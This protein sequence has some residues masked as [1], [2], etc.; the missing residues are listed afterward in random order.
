[1]IFKTLKRNTFLK[2]IILLLLSVRLVHSQDMN[3][4]DLD[5][6]IFTE[7]ALVNSHDILVLYTKISL[8]LK[9]AR[10]NDY[11]YSFYF[12]DNYS[13]KLPQTE[14]QVEVDSSYIGGVGNTL[15]FKFV[16]EKSTP[17]AILLLEVKSKVSGK[18]FLFDVPVYGSLPFNIFN[19]KGEP[20]V[21][22]WAI[23]GAYKLLEPM[24]TTFYYSHDFPPALPPMVTHQELEDKKIVVDS[25]FMVRG[26]LVL[27]KRGLYLSQTDTTSTK[28]LSFRVEDK[29]FPKF[30]TMDQLVEPLIYITSKE[31]Q[32]KLSKIN[33]EKRLFDK[34][35]LDLTKSP[36]RAK[37]I[38]RT[39]Y[40]RIESANRLF[41]TFKEGWKTDMGMIYIVMGAPDEVER[42]IKEETWVYLGN[43]DLPKRKFT[44]I[45][46]NSIFSSA[47]YVLIR[48]KKHAEAWF[49]AIDL[50]RKGI[51]NH[52]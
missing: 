39:Y 13:N 41:T 20:I 4:Y 1:L 8:N 18:L 17:K 5:S 52:N 25:T 2:T 44:F 21:N 11:S 43:R 15:F 27:A 16:L 37:N 32:E 35:W 29:Y 31:E 28:A 51:L 45:R 42:T 10:L 9:Q 12:I 46:S 3:R 24:V 7:N 47:H 34:F 36:E 40:D 22:N 6:E 23:P 19:K 14:K 26:S 33:G 30:T 48:E 49:E 38:I 50:L